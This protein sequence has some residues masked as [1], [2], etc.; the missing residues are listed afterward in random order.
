VSLQ[1]LLIADV[2]R[3]YIYHVVAE[4]GP[5]DPMMLVS[6]HLFYPPTA[7][8][9]AIISVAYVNQ[10]WAGGFVALQFTALR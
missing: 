3:I 6:E 10:L 1:F 9:R 7:V 2:Q 8:F 5:T 4:R